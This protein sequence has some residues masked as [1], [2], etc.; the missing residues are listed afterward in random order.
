[1]ELL[2]LLYLNSDLSS[3]KAK[4]SIQI[5]HTRLGISIDDMIKL[6]ITASTSNQV[7]LTGVTTY[8]LGTLAALRMVN[9]DITTTLF[10]VDNS[11]MF[12]KLLDWFT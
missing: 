12:V 2:K 4:E 5:V 7:I 3:T 6:N 8:D 1:M 10:G 9:P 11:N